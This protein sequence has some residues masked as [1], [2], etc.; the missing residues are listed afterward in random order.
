[1]TKHE[2]KSGLAGIVAPGF[3]LDRRDAVP[4]LIGRHDDFLFVTGLA[5][6]SRDIAALTKDGAHIYSMAGAMGGA[7]LIREGNGT[8][9]VLMRVAPTD[10][11]K[12]KRNLDPASCR[13]RFRAALG[14]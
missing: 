10:P 5:G 13:E 3:V 9:F 11:P 7:R 6:T 12:I 14:T 2:G 4:K 8:A 1:M